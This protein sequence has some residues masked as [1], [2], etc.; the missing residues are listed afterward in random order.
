MARLKCTE[1]G[2]SVSKADPVCRSCGSSLLEDGAT[3]EIPL[4]AAQPLVSVP[5]LQPTADAAPDRT[6]ARCP[7]PDCGTDIPDSRNLVCIEC[8]T[9][10]RPAGPQTAAPAAPGAS[11]TPPVAEGDNPYATVHERGG[12]RLVVSFDFG[13]VELSAG[14]ETMIGRDATDQ[15]LGRLND[16]MNVSRRHATIG[17]APHGAW[18]RDENSTNG[19]FVNG[20]PVKAGETADLAEGAELRLASDVRATVR[21]R[22]PGESGHE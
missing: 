7:N 16:M 11:A 4:A 21:F 3:T 6:P 17:L 5:S 13:H 19:T 1:C 18:I 8:M 9:E 15:R 20:R 22:R 10:L 14:Q 12:A 2:A